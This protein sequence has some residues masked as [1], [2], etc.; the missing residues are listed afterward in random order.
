MKKVTLFFIAVLTLFMTANVL[1]LTV[2]ISGTIT[3]D[4]SGTPVANHEVYILTD[5][6]INPSGYYFYTT[7]TTNANGFYD[8]TI[9][10]APDGVVT[11]FV[12]ET[13]DCQNYLHSDT[14][15][16]NN[17]P[18]VVDFVI[19]TGTP[20]PGCEANFMAIPDSNSE[21]S[22]HF[23]D[24]SIPAGTVISW[25]WDFGDGSPLGTTSDPHHIY[26]PIHGEYNVCL[27]ITTNT[28]CT[29]THCQI[30]YV[31]EPP[32]GCHAEFVSYPDSLPNT[33][34]W[35]F[36]S[37][38]TG[39]F[40]TLYWNFGDPGSGTNN[41]A[42]TQDPHHVFSAPGVYQVCLMISGDSCQNSTCHEIIVGE[43]PAG[44]HAEFISYSD[45][46]PDL[47]MHFVSQSTG[48]FVEMTWN[49]GDPASGINN[50]AHTQD[51]IHV[52]TAPGVYNVCLTIYGDSC[53]DQTC[54]EVVVGENTN[55]C[56]NHIVYEVNG[57][58]V[59][60]HGS[61]NSQFPTTYT[62]QM[63]DPAQTIL[64]GQF[65]TFTYP[66]AG[67]YTVLLTTVDSM[68]CT[69]TR[70]IHVTVGETT[71][72]LYG[73][74]YAG[75]SPVDHGIIYLYRS[76]EGVMTLA[77]SKEFGDSTGYYWFNN[78][79]AGHYYIKAELL[80]S[81][82]YFGSFAPTYYEHSVNWNSA[83]LIELGQP[84][85]P[86][87]FHMVEIGGYGEGPG[88]VNG[89]ITEGAKINGSGVGVPNV[90]VLLLDKDNIPL[91][92][93]LTDNNGQ[94]SFTD[95][96]YGQYVVYPEV[97]GK[98]TAP[99][100]IWLTLTNNT[101]TTDFSMSGSNIIFGINDNLPQYISAISNIFPNPMSVNGKITITTT[102][103]LN[104]VISVLDLTGQTVKEISPKL[105]RGE[106]IVSFNI[107]G[108]ASG[109][110]FLRITSEDGGSV[111]KK[112]TIGR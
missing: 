70:E 7:R 20:P 29:A 74:V 33:L 47:S 4:S 88:I 31:A 50:T 66:A 21:Y 100:A 22:I 5:S 16:S 23:I 46:I 103:D 87:N 24:T 9:T 69:W 39:N 89:T 53:Q 73:T 86:Y 8:C 93:T 107:S 83:N 75:N 35:H 104:L 38:S 30:V 49:F 67:I 105:S 98:V 1:G 28:S 14:I 91:T 45:S 90:E 95:V 3:S 36:W 60:Y 27:T 109:C 34:S 78:V 48:N 81:S 79:T 51:P 94:F 62:W 55:N 108:L 58:T 10:D 68:Y 57:L 85:N 99:A 80:P 59:T 25:L 101:I 111:V 15:M 72:N 77:D 42:S 112:F 110:Y 11:A 37:Q 26:P 19:C 12:V 106:N 17:S 84:N 63:G 13:F 56:E 18:V 61:T 71:F 76:A 6:L 65:V 64:T 40:T 44:C 43:P 102:R 32:L 82:S 96:A 54:H 2:H 92:Y 97:T 52:F 41:T